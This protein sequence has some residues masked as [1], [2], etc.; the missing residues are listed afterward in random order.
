MT[1]VLALGGGLNARHDEPELLISAL[2]FPLAVI[3]VPIPWLL[4]ALR[5]KCILRNSG[6]L[7][8]G[9]MSLEK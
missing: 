3:G 6:S 5:L 2:L 1:R 4:F 7:P 8:S 9:Q